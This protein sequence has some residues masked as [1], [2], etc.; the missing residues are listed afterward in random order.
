M[1]VD[2]W[3]ILTH[4]HVLRCHQLFLAT[5]RAIK[6][7]HQALYCVSCYWWDFLSLNR[8][9]PRPFLNTRHL[10]FFGLNIIFAKESLS[11]NGNR[12]HLVCIWVV[13]VSGRSPSPS[14]FTCSSSVHQLHTGNMS[15]S[16][17]TYSHMSVRPSIY[18]AHGSMGI[19]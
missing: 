11:F 15:V 1:L 7:L 12:T 13:V 14:G 5:K 6:P 17:S 8:L 3:F 4:V 19:Y 2:P 9:S 10:D 18:F 16:L